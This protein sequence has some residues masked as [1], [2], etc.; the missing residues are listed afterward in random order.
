MAEKKKAR[1]P[2]PKQGGHDAAR[3]RLIRANQALKVTVPGTDLEPFAVPLTNIPG[4][5]RKRVRA[6][7]N[8][9]FETM[10]SGEVG[11][12]TYVFLWWVSRII[13]GETVPLP[14]GGALPLSLAA[15]EDEWDERCAGIRLSDLDTELIQVHDGSDEEADPVG[16]AQG[17][18]D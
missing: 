17:Q 2:R 9:S 15:V 12:D 13:D 5:V 10:T 11:I 1:A 3:E 4:R 8:H 18:P 7:T 16:E 14:N 6:E